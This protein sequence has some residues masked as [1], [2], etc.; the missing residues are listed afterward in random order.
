M[1]G[2]VR[3]A[4]LTAIVVAICLGAGEGFAANVGARD[5]SSAPSVLAAQSDPN[6]P[7]APAA[8]A[9]APGPITSRVSPLRDTRG[10][11]PGL[12]PVPASP[13]AHP[14]RLIRRVHAAS[15][16]ATLDYDRDL[17]G[18][19]WTDNQTATW[20]KDGCSTRE[21]ILRRDMRAVTFK[22]DGE[23]CHVLTGVLRDSYTA[24]TIQFSKQ[25]PSEVQIDH[26]MAL[27]YDWAHGASNWS[28][29]KRKQIAND[30]LNLLA[31]DGP[32]NQAKGDDGPADWLPPNTRVR[33]A[34]A[35][36]FAQVSIKYHLAVT[37]PDKR[38]MLTVCRPPQ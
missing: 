30:P 1:T 5:T 38:V 6:A 2:A 7:L 8:P 34:Y 36:R 10:L 21:N 14:R 20:G 22:P 18:S 23:N 32:T 16:N 9:P 17:F 29:D 13:L 35:V 3:R 19:A 24:T 11:H 4:A 37:P 33:C 25:H 26:V 27:S 15:A 28:A 31:V 12:S